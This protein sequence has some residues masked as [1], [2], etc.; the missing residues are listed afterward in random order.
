ML[1]SELFKKYPIR[2]I[3]NYPAGQRDTVLQWIFQ[4]VPD[5]DWMYDIYFINPNEE[6]IDMRFKDELL[7]T[8]FMLKF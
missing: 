3:K 2:V 1:Q 8:A 4:H 6:A 7:A 5:G